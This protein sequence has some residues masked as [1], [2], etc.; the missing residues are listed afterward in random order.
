MV[1][2]KEE[3]SRKANPFWDMKAQA[4]GG[5]ET[6]LIKRAK[7][8]ESTSLGEDLVN[9]LQ[10]CGLQLLPLLVLNPNLN[11]VFQSRM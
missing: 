8:W 6:L 7:D 5:P 4:E 10:A 3:A 1:D 2:L 11:S 9:L